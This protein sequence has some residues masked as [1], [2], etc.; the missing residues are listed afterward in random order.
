M[1]DTV[2]LGL[3]A[4]T[5]IHVGI[6]QA[7]DALDLPVAREH[8][9]RFPH[10][11]GS[12]VKGAFKVWAK[13]NTTLTQ[14]VTSLFGAASGDDQGNDAGAGTLLFG[15]A[16][17]AMLPV[18]C[19]SDSYK[20]A[21]CPMIINRLLRDMERAGMPQTTV[22][23]SASYGTYLGRAVDG[24]PLG[25]EE[26]EF[27]HAGQVDEGIS[28]LLIALM[29]AGAPADF[30]NKLV[31]LSDND[32]KWF[33]EFG[34]PVAMRNALDV[35]K[36]VKTGALWAEETL[37]PDTVMWMVL[38]ERSAGATEQLTGAMN[39]KTY[40]QMGGNETIGQGWFSVRPV[41]AGQP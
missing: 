29:G 18:R 39:N 27:T 23:P 33:A 24:A 10:V 15:E 9:T 19:T 3:L 11:P 36:I 4:E 16:R 34:L 21:T 31:I 17:L 40:V 12:G 32:F 1:S 41:K 8:V 2:L 37:A 38:S 5:P 35:N 28:K 22:M 6:G 30:E 13:D 26:R 25:L 14:H 7:A 20:L